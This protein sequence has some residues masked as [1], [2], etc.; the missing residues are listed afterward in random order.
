MARTNKV[1]P[2][3]SSMNYIDR[4]A[5]NALAIILL[6]CAGCVLSLI[7]WHQEATKPTYYSVHQKGTELWLTPLN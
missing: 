6:L 1:R 7:Y 3:R 5:L 2:V 4:L